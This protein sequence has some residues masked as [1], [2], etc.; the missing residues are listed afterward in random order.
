MK[1]KTKR[2]KCSSI[3]LPLSLRLNREIRPNIEA[4]HAHD[5]PA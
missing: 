4:A 5:K 3:T 1:L 2:K